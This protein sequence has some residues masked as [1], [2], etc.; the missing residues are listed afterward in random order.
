ML[1]LCLT[2]LP[3]I[4]SGEIRH[5]QG[6]PSAIA[7]PALT[8]PPASLDAV[9]ATARAAHPG[10]V[11]LYLFAA[12][13]EERAWLVKLDTRPDTDER[14]ARFAR[15]D[16]HTAQLLDMPRFDQGVMAWVYRL[17]V[18]LFG[19]LPGRLFLGAMGA[20]FVVAIISGVVLYAP[21]MRRQPFASF[22]TGHARR[23]CWLDV[24][25]VLG[26][27][28]VVWALV[29]GGTGVIN[30]WADLILKSWQNAQ[31]EA[32]RG[33]GAAEGA[34]PEGA[35]IGPQVALQRAMGAHT[36][37][38]VTTVAFP[39][40]LLTTSQHYAVFLRGSTPLRSHLRDVVLVD[41]R[42]ATVIEGAGRPWYVSIFQMAQP[43]HFGDYGGLLFKIAWAVLDILTMVV[44]ISGLY[45]WWSRRAH[46][47]GA[48]Q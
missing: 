36:G 6:E 5:W 25:N 26:I 46:T 3:L 37:M 21:F 20:L 38:Q 39:G 24:H 43:L 19:G 23:T 12:E 41:R 22:R 15:I 45:L 14:A 28:T 35:E 40:T 30:T 2:G 7:D 48:G 9:T 1:L 8:T 32:L 33:Q 11:P 13:G 34:A 16:A 44:L 18:D 17:H 31:L 10:L 42:D 47:S 4:F 27:L 29:V